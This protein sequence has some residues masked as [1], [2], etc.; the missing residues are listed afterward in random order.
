[1]PLLFFDERV[2]D[3]VTLEFE[4]VVI[5]LTGEPPNSA[6]DEDKCKAGC[7]GPGSSMLLLDTATST[8]GWIDAGAALEASRPK[9]KLGNIVV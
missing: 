9:L 4:V 2:D 7:T 6:K 1:M 8:S 5:G 3:G